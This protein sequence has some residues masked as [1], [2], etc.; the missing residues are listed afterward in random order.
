MCVDSWRNVTSGQDGPTGATGHPERF[1]SHPNTTLFPNFTEWFDFLHSKGLKTYFND[2]PYQMDMQLSQKEVSF[3]WQ[4]L[5]STVV[6]TSNPS[7]CL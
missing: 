6:D 1:Y 2:H 3:R 5:V 4:G 7:S